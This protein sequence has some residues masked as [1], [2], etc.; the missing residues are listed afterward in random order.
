[1]SLIITS[2][3]QQEYDSLSKKTTGLENPASF[4]NFLKSPLIIEK[5]SEVALVSLKCSRDEDTVNIESGD[6]IFVY[7]GAENSQNMNDGTEGSEKPT[8]SDDINT[9]LKIELAEGVYSRKTFASHLQ[10]RLEDVIKKAYREVDTITVT[11]EF[12]T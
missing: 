5:D 8:E 7:W 10:A 6:G 4:Q 3:S 11:Q 12:D 1:M 9:P 2:S